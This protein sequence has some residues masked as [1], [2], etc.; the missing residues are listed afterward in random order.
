MKARTMQ[1]LK[2]FLGHKRQN[3]K[4]LVADDEISVA[5]T[6]FETS[7][8]SSESM[9]RSA[10]SSSLF[11][12]TFDETKNVQ[13][14]CTYDPQEPI[15]AGELWYTPSE[16]EQMKK[17]NKMAHLTA[18][19]SQVAAL[20]TLYSSCRQTK[21]ASPQHLA[22]TAEEDLSV[23]GLEAKVLP[24]LARDREQRRYALMELA[25]NIKPEHP[26]LSANDLAALLRKKSRAVTKPVRLFARQVAQAHAEQE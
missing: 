4:N 13:H 19:N 1:P 15:A 16:N 18:A 5:S 25:Y 9:K 21:V 6:T 24:T 17:A 11:R 10:K 23:L 2:K 26:H 12:V 7:S 8:S 3:Q 22:A 14:D 20:E